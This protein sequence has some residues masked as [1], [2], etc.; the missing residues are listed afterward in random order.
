MTRESARIGATTVTAEQK[1]ATSRGDAL[2]GGLG[3]R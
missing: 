2:I 1:L 3:A